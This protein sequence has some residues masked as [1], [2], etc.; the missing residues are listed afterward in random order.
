[1]TNCKNYSNPSSSIF[2]NYLLLLKL[3]IIPL[4]EYIKVKTLHIFI[5]QINKDMANVTISIYRKWHPV[6]SSESLI[7]IHILH[8][9]WCLEWQLWCR[10]RN[11]A[12]WENI[13]TIKQT[14]EKIKITYSF[15]HSSISLWANKAVGRM[16][17]P[18][19]RFW[20]DIK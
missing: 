11:K 17:I 1:M 19:R 16:I 10:R 6:K 12:F 8:F 2:S 9:R 15:G 3:V 20:K 4:Q 18:I 7:K 14:K 5:G 13:N